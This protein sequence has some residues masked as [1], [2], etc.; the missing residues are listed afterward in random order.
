MIFRQ[1]LYKVP[2]FSYKNQTTDKK[3]DILKVKLCDW[4]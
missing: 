2:A 3:N 1:V 4:K